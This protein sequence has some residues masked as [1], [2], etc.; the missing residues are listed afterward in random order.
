VLAALTLQT[1]THT[2]THTHTPV[3]ISTCSATPN[4]ETQH[5]RRFH[6]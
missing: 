5:K 1:H 3:E 2:H 6:C 4:I